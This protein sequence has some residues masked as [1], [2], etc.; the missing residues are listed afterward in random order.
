MNKM[1]VN[2]EVQMRNPTGFSLSWST[3]YC[4]GV[5]FFFLVTLCWCCC[6]V[7]N[8]VVVRLFFCMLNPLTRKSTTMQCRVMPGAWLIDAALR[9]IVV[10]DRDS[11]FTSCRS[12]AIFSFSGCAAKTE[13]PFESCHGTPLWARQR[14][15]DA[16]KR[17]CFF[18]LVAGFLVVAVTLGGGRSLLWQPF[19]RDRVVCVRTII[20][21]P[22]LHQCNG[23]AFCC[24]KNGKQCHFCLQN[25]SS[26]LKIAYHEVK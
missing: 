10:V 15:L 14:G 8:E 11:R 25:V 2:G 9:V 6:H 20:P 3:I 12:V 1:Y 4:C 17:S 18:H 16:E 26:N 19:I 5:S 23:N 7:M 22:L 24:Q 21:R 13:R